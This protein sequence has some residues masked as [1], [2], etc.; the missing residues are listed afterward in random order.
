M[1]GQGSSKALQPFCPGAAASSD[2]GPTIPRVSPF[3]GRSEG[4]VVTLLGSDSLDGLSVQDALL[5]KKTTGAGETSNAHIGGN[6]PN[7]RLRSRRNTE[8]SV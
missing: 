6:S 1:K 4:N 2:W 8:G 5:L 3:F 7:L